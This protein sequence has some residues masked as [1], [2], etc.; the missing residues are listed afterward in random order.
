MALLQGTAVSTAS[1]TCLPACPPPHSAGPPRQGLL[2]PSPPQP[3][4]W[5]KTLVKRDREEAIPGEESVL[6]REEIALR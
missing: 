1:A 3:W 5:P 4:V 2:L 6:R